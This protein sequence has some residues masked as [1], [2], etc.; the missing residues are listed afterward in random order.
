MKK[1]KILLPVAFTV[2]FFGLVAQSAHGQASV[3][4]GLKGG[5]NFATLSGTTSFA[6]AYDN[7]TGY[8]F[9]AYTLFKFTK[10]G[11]QPELLFSKQ[12]QKFTVNSQNFESNFD[13]ISI[14]VMFKLYLAAGFNFQAGPQFSF[15]TSAKGDVINTSTSG[16]TTGQDLKNFTKSTD[17]SVS[18][19]AGWD[20]PFGLNIAARYN[21]GISDINELTGAPPP[22][23]M[24]SMGLSAS[25]NQVIQVSV[26]MR[27]F[28]LGN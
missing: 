15:L 16:V 14:P 2:L 1:M 8:H 20:L 22:A 28:K 18:L 27:L 25:K 4:I 24:S 10:I 5:L 7:R 17:F 23:Q 13:Y 9:G 21:I 19:G 6:S 12:G 11:I 3:S 26:G